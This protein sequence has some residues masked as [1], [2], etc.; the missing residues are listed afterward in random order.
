MWN[1]YL[2]KNDIK[3][4]YAPFPYIKK[5]NDEDINEMMINYMIDVY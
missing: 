2:K 1:S 4:V 3:I 5:S